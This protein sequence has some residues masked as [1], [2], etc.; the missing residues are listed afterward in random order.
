MAAPS[1][2]LAQPQ[3]A[4]D[5]GRPW[6]VDELVVAAFAFLGVAGAVF[7][8]LRFNIP[9][10]VISFLLATGLAAFAY[11]YLG[12][13]PAGTSYVTGTLK[14]GGALAALVGIAFAI[15]TVLVS[16]VQFRLT[17]DDD[18]VGPWKWVYGR[19]ASS[20]HIYIEKDSQN[21]LVFK[22]S[23]EKYTTEN[24]FVPLYTLTNGKAKLVNRNSLMM[25]VDVEDHVNKSKFHWKSDSPIPLV[26]A[27]R[28][29]MRATRPD[30]TEMPYTWGITFYK[31]SGD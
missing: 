4:G 3:S 15:N 22:G 19:G 1:N 30:G 29:T 9:P 28:G 8:P 20:G 26:P 5:R 31:Q 21:N 24:E 13:I 18:I 7:L 12:G 25:E 2:T 16:Q 11:K 10:I 27:F 14:L 6:Y 17:T 23:Q